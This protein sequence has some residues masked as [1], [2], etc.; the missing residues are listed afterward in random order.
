MDL[1]FDWAYLLAAAGG[2]WSGVKSV[3][4]VAEGERGILLTFGK[5]RRQPD[6]TVRVF[7]PGF[8]PIIPFAQRIAKTH[9]QKNTLWFENLQVTL[10]N[11]LSYTFDAYVSY[12]IIDEPQWIE[13]VLFTLEDSVEFVGVKFRTIV[14]ESL[15]NANPDDVMDIANKLKREV[16]KRL[17]TDGIQVDECGISSFAETLVSQTFR[18][19]DYRIE[20]ALEFQ[21][22]LPTAVLSAALGAMSTVSS[23][24][25][26]PVE[27]AQTLE[28]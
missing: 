16:G 21:G 19:I 3:S 20:K 6:G 25:C 17:R 8:R 13:H 14:Q 1:N 10:G 24:D 15:W 7:G 28:E 9:M 2:I 5:A 22:Q 23:S 26:P 18:G 12:H 11:N 27:P 4:F